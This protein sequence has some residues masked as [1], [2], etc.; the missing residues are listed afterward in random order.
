MGAI[1]GLHGARPVDA[2][3]AM[4]GMSAALECHGVE[5]PGWAQGASAFGARSWP[6]H[7]EASVVADEAAGISLVADVRLY[8]R[9]ALCDALG[10]APAARARTA[11]AAL[12]LL[13]YKRWGGACAERLEGDYAFAVWDRRRDTL[14][15]WR[16][17][18]G[19]RP[20]YYAHEG[21]AFAFG[22][23]VQAV[24]AAPGI[25]AGLDEG[26]V[27]AMFV[28]PYQQPHPGHTL[29]RAV[30]RLRP[31]HALE[32]RAGV[33]RAFRR[34]RPEEAPRLRLGAP[35]AYA[36]AL[37]DLVTRAVEDRLRGGPIALELS[38]G[39]DSSA[40]SVLAAR[41][42]R[43]AGG[44]PVPTFTWLPRPPTPMPAGWAD[45][46][47]RVR[48]VAAQERLRVFYATF[49]AADVEAILRLD[50]AL[51]ESSEHP[52][53]DGVYRQ[54]REQGARVLLT[55]RFG[56]ELA[57]SNGF[58]HE[59][60]LLLSGRWL[61]LLGRTRTEG[62]GVLKRAA[63][64][65]GRD[66]AA[67]W[68]SLKRRLWESS[69]HVNLANPAYMGQVNLPARPALSWFGGVR[70]RQL[71]FLLGGEHDLTFEVRTAGA[72]RHGIECRHP[73]IDRRIVEF[74]LGVPPDLFRRDGQSRW[75]MR[76][77]LRCVLPDDVRLNQDKD[78]PALEGREMVQ[79]WIDALP[80]LRQR[81]AAAEPSRTRYL[82]MEKV[83]AG[84]DETIRAQN[85]PR[86]R[87]IKA[88]NFLCRY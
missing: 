62:L 60:H 80:T 8:D 42:S 20:F 3:A 59:Q 31:G 10:V 11:D 41:L 70:D 72:A 55:G 47:S 13:A 79:P 50:S 39:L 35:D 83:L 61:P 45:S 22:T 7:A 65:T 26:A 5:H 36:D 24:L 21:G 63:R 27:V 81:A 87:F 32:L 67:V 29:L 68:R 30:R 34:W 57:S 23:S 71:R 48:S 75:L 76:R 52:M 73:L 43:A 37:L 38:G 6:G 86:V 17:P 54:A 69:R 1:W 2:A 46:Y 77:A 49:S 12:L 51:P 16:S 64:G 88:L 15:C 78:D 25:P 82:H 4:A 33:L 9:A 84:L 56:D 18:A 28:R 58:W 14:F 40:V 44:A 53:V 19:E 85:A 74:V 66:F